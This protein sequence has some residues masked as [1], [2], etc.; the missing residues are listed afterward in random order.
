M[1]SSSSSNN[2]NSSTTNRLSNSYFF[3]GTHPLKVPSNIN[4]SNST[5]DISSTYA[6]TTHHLSLQNGSIS[7]TDNAT[8]KSLYD[9]SKSCIDED[10]T[11]EVMILFL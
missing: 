8:T 3:Y 4:Y 6:Q 1:A 5:N 2:N 11:S 10:E 7:I 9:L